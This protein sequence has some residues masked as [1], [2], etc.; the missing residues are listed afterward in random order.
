MTLFG[1]KDG[2]KGKLVV[3]AIITLVT[4]LLVENTTHIIEDKLLNQSMSFGSRYDDS[5]IS[6]KI[7]LDNPILGTGPV[8]EHTEVFESYMS[9]MSFLRESTGGLSRSNGLGLFLM[10]CGFPLTI[11]YLISIYLENKK[12]LGTSTFNSI[13]VLVVLVCGLCNEPIAFTTL[14][15][16]FFMTWKTPSTNDEV[17]IRG[18]TNEVYQ[19]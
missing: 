8:N 7:A 10:R 6:L 18:E 17:L 14:W 1:K 2:K 15:L 12:I 3:F 11:I 9:I 16:S 19:N 4:L 5:I 13:L